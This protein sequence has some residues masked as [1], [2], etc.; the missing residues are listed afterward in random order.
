MRQYK[1]TL[2]REEKFRME[3]ASMSDVRA[4]VDRRQNEDMS[5][6]DFVIEEV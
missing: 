1:V 5:I 2:V 6:V 4:E 3:A